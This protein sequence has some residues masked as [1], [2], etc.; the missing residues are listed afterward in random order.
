MGAMHNDLN[1]CTFL[2]SDDRRCRNLIHTPGSPLCYYH[3]FPRQK[4][5]PAPSDETAAREFY[6]WLA[7]HPLDNATHVNQALNQ[8]FFLLIGKRIS[9]RRAEALI[10]VARLQ[11]KSVPDVH[12]E[13]TNSEYARRHWPQ[14]SNFLKEIQPLLASVVPQDPPPDPD[15]AGV[16]CLPA[17]PAAPPGAST[18]PDRSAA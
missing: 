12:K 10:R 14:G 1:R 18:A 15:S 4:R 7:A 5:M 2:Y 8:I 11:M 9:L 16:F 17:P 6:R 13:F 3:A